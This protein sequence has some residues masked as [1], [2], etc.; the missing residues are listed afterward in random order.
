MLGC[1]LVVSIN[2]AQSEPRDPLKIGIATD[3]HSVSK[4]DHCRVELIAL[5]KKAFKPLEAVLISAPQ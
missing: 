5:F 1:W 2:Q 4:G 3:H